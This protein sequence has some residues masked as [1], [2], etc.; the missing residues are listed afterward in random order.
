VC[1]KRKWGQE[2]FYPFTFL[3]GK[4]AGSGNRETW[5]LVLD[6]SSKYRVFFEIKYLS[7]ERTE[8]LT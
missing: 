6:K 1:K 5:F 2:L 8:E 3:E 4:N 7:K